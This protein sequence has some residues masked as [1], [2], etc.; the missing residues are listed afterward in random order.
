LNLVS[1]DFGII[2]GAYEERML[3]M[4]TAEQFDMIIRDG[5]DS[6]SARQV[7]TIRSHYR[8]E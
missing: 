1:R 5:K 2:G 4:I 8:L 6:L 7:A 3:N